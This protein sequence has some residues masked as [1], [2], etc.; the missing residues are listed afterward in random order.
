[1][2]DFEELSK[3]F[4]FKSMKNLEKLKKKKIYDDMTYLIIMQELLALKM[5]LS[6]INIEDSNSK[7]LKELRIFDSINLVT[8]HISFPS[9]IDNLDFYDIDTS[10]YNKELINFL[11]LT[12]RVIT[13]KLEDENDKKRDLRPFEI[14][15]KNDTFDSFNIYDIYD[16]LEGCDDLFENKSIKDDEKDNKLNKNEKKI[17]DKNDNYLKFEYIKIKKDNENYN[18]Y[19]PDIYQL[20]F[21]G[22]IE[23]DIKKNELGKLSIEPIKKKLIMTVRFKQEWLYQETSSFVKNKINLEN[24]KGIWHKYYKIMGSSFIGFSNKYGLNVNKIIFTYNKNKN[25]KDFLE[26]KQW[27]LN[28]KY[29]INELLEYLKLFYLDENYKKCK[30]IYDKITNEINKDHIKKLLPENLLNKLKK[31]SKNNYIIPSE[32]QE[33]IKEKE[34][35]CEKSPDPKPKKWLDTIKKIPFGYHKKDKIFNFVSEFIEKYGKKYDIKSFT[36]IYKNI[37]KLDENLK[38]KWKNY[39]NERRE[40]ILTIKNH[41]DKAVYGHEKV[42]NEI[43]SLVNEWMNGSVKGS[44]IGIQGPP[45]NGK[46]SIAKNGICNSFLDEEGNKFPF[47]YISLGSTNNGSHL[48]GHHYTFQG[49]THGSI[50]DGLIRSECMNPIFYFDELDKI[51]QTE[52]GKEITNTLIH[53]TDFTQNDTF[54]DVYFS[55]IKLDL[56]KCLFIFSFNDVHKIDRVLK[57]RLHIINT[58]SLNLNEKI[59]IGKDYLM[60]E[61]CNNIS[62][63]MNDININKNILEYIIKNYTFEAGVR[64]LKRLL[65]KIV[66]YFNNILGSNENK[67][68]KFPINI[69][70]EEIDQILDINNKIRIKKTHSNPSIG[71]VNGLYCIPDY[72]VGGTIPLQAYRTFPK[73]SNTTEITITGNL[74]KVMSEST[75]CA[76][77]TLWSLIDEKLKEN[78]KE[79]GYNIHLHALDGSTPKEGPSAGAAITLCLYSLI[80]E[81]KVRN[82]VALTGEIT[83]DGKVGVIG[84]VAE[85]VNGGHDVGC[86]IILLPKDNEKDFNI[87]LNDGCFSNPIRI[88]NENETSDDV[89][90]NELCVKFIDSINDVIKNAIV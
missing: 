80:T 39:I 38:L 13:S 36:D 31:E 34:D 9:L 51:S 25:N 7:E 89:K 10:L 50:V 81:K 53:L 70:N 47:V 14:Y 46:T 90:N 45:G 37:D 3:T 74:G 41:L 29:D 52:S 85:K 17:I 44:V 57:D 1:M 62:W 77:T 64:E 11:N 43:V 86:N 2:D 48:F 66:R 71:I 60:K 6:K 4:T 78:I 82:N 16:N 33:R 15:D 35:E 32:V 19:F 63:N 79:K 73:S 42:K 55:G 84:G 5:N 28:T 24:K 61:I 72:G 23:F 8:K 58:N 68:F 67:N 88:L 12:C 69:D 40:K 21:P 75:E 83:L 56:S 30:S 76:K 20:I 87:A 54:E 59:T 49:S 27:D 26:E 18:K 65:T 22:K